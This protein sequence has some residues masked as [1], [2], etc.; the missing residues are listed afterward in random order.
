MARRADFPDFL[1]SALFLLPCFA[2]CAAEAQTSVALGSHWGG[3]LLP[4]FQRGW[5]GG[6]AFLSFTEYDSEGLKY[7]QTP[8]DSGES[9]PDPSPETMGFNLFSLAYSNHLN[10]EA[11]ELANM[12]YRYGASL[13]V[14]GDLLTEHYQN[15]I[16]HRAYRDF[17]RVERH[18]VRCDEADFGPKCLDYS[19]N[20]EI[21]Y[22][23]TNLDLEDRLRFS[24]SHFFSGAG[25]SLSS[26][27]WEGYLQFGLA[28][29]PTLVTTP[30]FGLRVASAARL[31]G[32]MQN[33]LTENFGKPIFRDLAP[34]YYLVQGGIQIRFFENVYP[35]ILG[36]YL[37]YHSGY[38]L[39]DRGRPIPTQFWTLTIDIDQLY[40]ET[41]NDMPSGTD[42]GPTFGVR[43]YWDF[44]GSSRPFKALEAFV[45]GLNRP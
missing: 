28:D 34:G 40:F 42:F 20:G 33:P 30:W 13:G 4:S 15:E 23:F 11:T 32:V 12:L 38:W 2:A 37:S 35:L 43:V 27:A 7:G 14:N 41:F 44:E 10:P 6:L 22:R 25:M 19:L 8:R 1:K 45:K 3:L 24:A 31:G 9:L 39:D 5:Q 21:L 16:I 18:A 29:F 26:V 17:P 36:N